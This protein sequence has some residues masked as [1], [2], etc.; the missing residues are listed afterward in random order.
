MK[1]SSHRNGAAKSDVVTYNATDCDDATLNKAAAD[2]KC[3]PELR[4]RNSKFT[5]MLPVSIL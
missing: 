4:E 2:L 1:R 5:T 3:K